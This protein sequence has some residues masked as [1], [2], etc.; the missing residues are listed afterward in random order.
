MVVVGVEPARCPDAV[1]VRCGTTQDALATLRGEHAVVVFRRQPDLGEFTPADILAAA[2]H[3]LATGLRAP[4]FVF[5]R[6][7]FRTGVVPLVLPTASRAFLVALAR[8]GGLLGPVGLELRPANFAGTRSQPF[9]RV[10][11]VFWHAS[12]L[13]ECRHNF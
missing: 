12:T 3:L 1:W 5:T 6:A 2:S 8:T 9:R 7:A 10:S 4:Q 11:P 13:L